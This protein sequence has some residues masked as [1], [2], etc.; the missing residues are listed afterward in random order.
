MSQSDIQAIRDI[1][2]KT[3]NGAYG[4]KAIQKENGEVIFINEDQ[5]STPISK[6]DHKKSKIL[7]KTAS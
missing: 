1:A 7:T 2:L 3:L 5:L 4:L 6:E